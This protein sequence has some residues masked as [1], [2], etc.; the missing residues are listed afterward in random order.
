MAIGNMVSHIDLQAPVLD[1]GT[2]PPLILI[3]LSAENADDHMESQRCIAYT[4]CNLSAEL[5]DRM[6]IIIKGGLSSI[7]YLCHTDTEDTFDMLAALSTLPGLVALD[8]ARPLNSQVV[9]SA[10]SLGMNTQTACNANNEQLVPY[11]CF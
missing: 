7:M 5:H 8:E 9:F 6:S 1:S 10:L 2:L 4:I 11:W 3:G